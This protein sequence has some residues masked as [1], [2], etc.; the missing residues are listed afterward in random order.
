MTTKQEQEETIANSCAENISE[1]KDVVPPVSVKVSETQV[2]SSDDSKRIAKIVQQLKSRDI[3]A[4]FVKK[5]LATKTTTYLFELDKRR[6]SDVGK[7]DTLTR[8]TLELALETSGISIL[9]PVPDTSQIAVIVPTKGPDSVR[10]P[11]F[12]DAIR[13]GNYKIPCVLGEDF[14]GKPVVTD[15]AEDCHQLV[16]G[17]TGS[18]KSM[19]LK[20]IITAIAMTCDHQSLKLIIVDGKGIDFVAFDR[21]LH[22]ACPVITDSDRALA[23]LRW[24]CSE[25]ERRRRLFQQRNFT[26]IWAYNNWCTSDG[27]EED[28][29]E[30][31]P[32]L[33]LAVDEVQTLV[34]YKNEE[35][36]SMLRHI[37][38]QG[39]AYGI[40][41][42]LATQ[43]PSVD[44]LQGTIKTNLS[45][46]IS[47]YLP[48]SADSRVILD[49]GGAE[50]LRHKGD[51]LAIETS[52]N[53]VTRLQAPL[54]TDQEIESVCSLPELAGDYIPALIEE[55][56]QSEAA[57]PVVCES[58]AVPQRGNVA[59]LDTPT[60]HVPISK[61]AE[62]IV[63]QQCVHKWLQQK[64]G[65][66]TWHTKLVYLPFLLGEV[67]K[68][69]H[70]HRILY[71]MSTDCF[72]MSLAAAQNVDLRCLKDLNGE[73]EVLV[74]LLS[75]NSKGDAAHNVGP[76]ERK[77]ESQMAKLIER[78][79]VGM[80]SKGTF[81]LKEYA[82]VPEFSGKL[83]LTAVPEAPSVHC[84]N[85]S[86]PTD[87]IEKRLRFYLSRIWQA[88]LEN[89]SY[90]GVPFYLSRSTQGD[91][92]TCPACVRTGKLKTAFRFSRV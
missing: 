41:V 42:I 73:L 86:C 82:Q 37:T 16:A 38:Q 18:G 46:R 2:A 66:R 26:H 20:A 91:V 61:F 34:N 1:P 88:S 3:R 92:L 63:E 13:R 51:L 87:E 47:F 17:A 81:V 75:H 8:Q 10:L 39:R 67:R 83:G 40:V 30:V 50:L 84:S 15:L 54:V 22:L 36:E 57:V 64:H 25:I 79:L 43:R 28:P 24:L 56:N 45:G 6:L 5:D 59:Q 23:A 85:T 52:L 89:H 12:A 21:L 19:L 69:R 70:K 76:V 48:S 60:H 4:K 11:R 55:L 49:Q 90:I 7:I 65:D 62:V 44:I 32:A 33:L 74:S 35:V 53:S 14:T 29:S 27:S 9:A 78:G 68:D 58:T 72:V 31:L 80:S 77:E 71:D